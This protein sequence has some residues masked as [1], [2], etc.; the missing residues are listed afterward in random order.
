M[1]PVIVIRIDIIE[2]TVTM[3]INVNPRRVADR[4]RRWCSGASRVP[5]RWSV[6]RVIVPPA[7]RSMRTTEP[8]SPAFQRGRATRPTRSIAERPVFQIVL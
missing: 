1:T 5:G 4:R 7:E 3:W 6:A 8:V 2:I